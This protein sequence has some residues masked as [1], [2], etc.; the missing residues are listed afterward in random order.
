MIGR[1]EQ[2][3]ISIGRGARQVGSAQSLSQHLRR[4]WPALAV[5]LATSGCETSSPPFDSATARSAFWQND[6]ATAEKLYRAGAEQGN[7]EAQYRLGRMYQLGWGVPLEY[8]EA[9]HWFRRAADSGSLDAQYELAFLMINGQGIDRNV[10]SGIGRLISAAEKGHLPS[11][12]YLANGYRTNARGLPRDY[13]RAAM[14]ERVV[15]CTF[16]TY[17]NSLPEFESPPAS[18]ARGVLP[19]KNQ[20]INRPEVLPPDEA[21]TARQLADR[22]LRARIG[23]EPGL[24]GTMPLDCLEMT[25]S[26]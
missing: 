25:S 24:A 2:A 3:G 23:S 26:G 12:A 11:Q 16:Q 5:L 17:L 21:A 6:F 15:Y 14:W 1:L 9:A 13:V 18:L 7:A 10:N 19:P 4:L 8:P 22:W 20:L